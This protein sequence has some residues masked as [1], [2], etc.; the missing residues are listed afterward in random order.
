MSELSVKFDIAEVSL[1]HILRTVIHMS[2]FDI[3]N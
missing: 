2:F 1:W 3:N